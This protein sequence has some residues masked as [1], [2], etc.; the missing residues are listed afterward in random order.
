MVNPADRLIIALDV[1]DLGRAREIVESLGDRGGFYKIGYQLAFAGGFELISELKAQ[2]KKV[3]LDLKLLDID[4]T[5]AKGV[6]NLCKLGVDMLTVHAYPKTMRAAVAAARDYP[7][8][9]LG[10]TVL[11]SLDDQD[12][13]EAG[14]AQSATE[15][16]LSRARDAHSAGMGGVVASAREAATLRSE[17]GPEMAIVTPGIRPLGADI[18][19]QKRVVAPG[20]AI[21]AGASHLVVGRPI[22]AAEDKV[23]A[24]QA[25]LR[26]MS[27][28]LQTRR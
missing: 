22:V 10:V 9:V 15:L 11:T 5:V 8:C 25:I 4:N 6:E 28:A 18:G 26:E 12:L 1:P 7:V 27:E 14:Y 24:A 3:F 16:V 19:D 13:K 21:R 20:E 17:I 23:H 2:G